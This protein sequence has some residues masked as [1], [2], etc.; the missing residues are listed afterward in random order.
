MIAR[1][2]NK[3]S[4][5]VPKFIINY[6]ES[7]KNEWYINILVGYIWF[8]LKFVFPF[9]EGLIVD[10]AIGFIVKWYIKWY[11]KQLLELVKEILSKYSFIFYNLNKNDIIRLRK[12]IF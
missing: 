8:R 2:I 9:H 3:L 1:I 6:I 4:T 10:F 11:L 7:W 12:R 5:G